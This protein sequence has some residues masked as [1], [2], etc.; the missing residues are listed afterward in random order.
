MADEKSVAVIVPFLNE[1]QALPSLVEALLRLGPQQIIF[2]DGGSNDGGMEWLSAQSSARVKVV[3]CAAGR[4]QQMNYGAGLATA[5]IL[6]FLHADTRLPEQAMTEV[7]KGVWGRFDIRFSDNHSPKRLSLAVVQRMINLR[8]RLS[9]VATG[10]QAMFVRRCLF[11]KVNGFDNIPLMEDV[12]LSKT[13]KQLHAPYC[14][15]FKVLTSARRW[16][17]GGVW[18][19]IV[20]MWFLRFA[21]L[22]GV[23]P[24]RLSRLYR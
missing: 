16:K 22:I 15:S 17:T 9:N 20:L 8:S 7:Q 3:S 18:R 13:L 14:S 2:V 21:Y 6:V 23:S 24:E 1:M 11:E 4:A 19:T 10:D 12:Q 5:E